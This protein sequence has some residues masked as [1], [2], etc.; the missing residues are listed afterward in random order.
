MSR[1]I[2]ASKRELSKKELS[3]RDTQSGKLIF[4]NYKGRK[5]ALLCNDNRLVSAE[6]LPNTPSKIGAIYIGKV[7][8]VVSN[9]DACFV[10]IKDGELCFLPLKEAQTPFVLNRVY[11]GRIK[12]GDELLIQVTRDAQKTKQASVTAHISLSNDYFA[13]SIGSARIGFSGKLNRETKNTIRTFLDEQQI[14]QNGNLVQEPD[15]P[16]V[17]MVVRTQANELEENQLLAAYTTMR[18][19]FFT[20]LQS[21]KH[22][23]CFSCLQEPN[24]SV[25]AV[26]DQ[27]VY[28]YEYDEIITDDTE[29][30]NKLQA[31][32]K[33][34]MPNKT[35]RLYEDAMLPLE[36]LYSISSKIDTA[37]N[38][39]VWLKSGGYLIIE[40][41]EG[42]TVIDVNS[43]KYAVKKVNPDTTIMINQEAAREIALQL[44]LRNLSGIIVVDFINMNSEEANQ[45]LLELL[46]KLV[47]KDKI[48]TKAVDMTPLGL[49]EITRKKVRKPLHEQFAEVSHE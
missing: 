13:F 6:V 35:L 48:K 30:Y 33:L 4:T 47:Q 23:T 7:K 42:L 37:L 16:S 5:W 29:I 26:L 1:N 32:C 46:R 38:T 22:R 44:R 34:H 3:L 24:D 15:L 31:Y 8:N 20:L 25:H 14:A 19:A 27:V 12:E 49:V 43:G 41:T 39:R 2:E 36:K 40:P 10:E 11:D 28:P 9:I 21:A 17:G 45:E 18:E